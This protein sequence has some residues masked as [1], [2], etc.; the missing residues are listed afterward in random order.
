MTLRDFQNKSSHSFSG[1]PKCSAMVGDTLK[2]KLYIFHTEDEAKESFY[3][4]MTY[5]HI[6][7]GTQEAYDCATNMGQCFS[8]VCGTDLFFDALKE[9][10]KQD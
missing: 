2:H 6:L 9:Q 7:Q 1:I 8:N 10:L 5:E 3:D 4:E